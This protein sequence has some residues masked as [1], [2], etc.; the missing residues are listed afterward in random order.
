MF[1]SLF[2]FFSFFIHSLYSLHLF[3]GLLSHEHRP[4]QTLQ[5]PLTLG[6]LL[7][8]LQGAMSSLHFYLVSLH[9]VFQGLPLVLFHHGFLVSANYVKLPTGFLRVWW[10]QP[11]LLF[12]ICEAIRSWIFVIHRSLLFI[13]SGKWRQ[14][15]CTDN[16]GRCRSFPVFSVAFIK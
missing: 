13:L 3:T 7:H 14:R 16:F 6:C 12:R 8:V 1:F 5:Q 9:H 2:C 15:L 10:I 11:H 4:L